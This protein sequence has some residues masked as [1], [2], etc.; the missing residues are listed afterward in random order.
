MGEWENGGEE[1]LVT[2]ERFC[3]ARAP[4]EKRRKREGEE[5]TELGN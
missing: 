1:R 3:L 5:T 2:G 4:C